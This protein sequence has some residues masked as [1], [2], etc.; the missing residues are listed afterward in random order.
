MAAQYFSTSLLQ[1]EKSLAWSSCYPEG[2][3]H[4]CY[5]QVE[6]LRPCSSSVWVRW[7][8]GTTSVREIDLNLAENITSDHKATA[9]DKPPLAPL[10]KTET[11]T[12]RGK[13]K[14]LKIGDRDTDL[15]VFSFSNCEPGASEVL[16]YYLQLQCLY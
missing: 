8:D 15:S 10:S 4:K 12:A 5:G 2:E 14:K 9:S 13:Q 6:R 3:W 16:M 1:I 7:S 11:P